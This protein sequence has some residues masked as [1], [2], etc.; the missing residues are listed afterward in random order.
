MNSVATYSCKGLQPVLKP[1]GPQLGV[2]SL[3]GLDGDSVG[4]NGKGLQSRFKSGT[5]RGQYFLVKWNWSQIEFIYN[6]YSCM[7][8]LAIGSQTLSSWVD[9]TSKGWWRFFEWEWKRFPVQI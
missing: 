2:I 3:P 7:K 9:F 4:G 8:P 5:N 6:I 1:S